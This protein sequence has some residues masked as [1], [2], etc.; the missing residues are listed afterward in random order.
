[1]ENL[2]KEENIL[3]KVFRPNIIRKIIIGIIFIFFGVFSFIV[4]KDKLF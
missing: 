2:I 4:L 1:M 3:P